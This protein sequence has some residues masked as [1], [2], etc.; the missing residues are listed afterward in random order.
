[1]SRP[2]RQ[3]LRRPGSLACWIGPILTLFLVGCAQA[4]APIR[5]QA[6]SIQQIPWTAAV[7]ELDVG[8]DLAG[9]GQH[10]SAVLVASDTIVT[11]AHCLFL[12][13]AQAPASP[14]NLNF[15]PNKGALPALPPSRGV[16]FKGVGGIIRGGKLRD[17]DVGND[18]AL[19]AISPPV[20]GVQPLPVAELPI[21]GMLRLVQSGDRLV[22]AGYGNGAYEE[23]RLHPPCRI[24]PQSEIGLNPTDDIVI[25]SCEFRT[26]DAGG[27][28]LLIDGA[29]QPALIGIFSGFGK[30][31]KTAEPLGLGVNARNFTPY[32]RQGAL[33]SN[34]L[35]NG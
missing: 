1:M 20:V 27:P 16:A 35:Q 25:T 24:I 26:G 32:L 23:L 31:P 9:S 10:C 6:P 14:Y 30:N 2:I 17:A 3:L 34:E 7:G 21:S 29:G 12:G 4:Q 22:T 18:W 33:P 28:I 15:Y 13:S 19:V 8:N 5:L 11:A